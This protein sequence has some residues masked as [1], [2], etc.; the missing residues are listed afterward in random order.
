MKKIFTIIMLVMGISF[1][2]VAQNSLNTTLIG[3]WGYG[4]CYTVAES[5]N[6]A[7][8]GSG[9]MLLA[10]D[11]TIPS[12]PQKIG[13]LSLPDVIND[14]KIS[15]N[16]AYIADN[17]T[18]LRIINISNPT[19]LQ[20]TG[21]YDTPGD[22]LG[23]TVSGN[24]A[25]VADKYAGLRIID[26]SNPAS[27]QEVGFYNTPGIASSVSISGNYAYIADGNFYG[28]R[29]VDISNP[30]CPQEIGAYGMSSWAQGVSVSRNYV[31]VADDD[32]G[33]RIIDVS[34]PASPQE[35]GFYATPERALCV[36]VSGNYAYVAD[37]NAGML[38]IQND[39]LVGIDNPVSNQGNGYVQNYPNPFTSNTTLTFNMENKAQVNLSFYD[40]LGNK[41]T[42]LLNKELPAGEY[43]IP[44]D[45]SGLKNG[46]YYYTLTYGNITKTGKMVKAE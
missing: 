39:L 31:Y 19:N 8:M 41:V 17:E 28:L 45:G 44:F 21:F 32:A 43:Q 11:K 42:E 27:P 6:Y 4:P 35:V 5:G 29:I 2:L 40:C 18:G 1:S 13:E 24:Y 12:T 22:A 16:Y 3:H 46:M 38:I 25:Y 9:C 15:G 33:L 36:T 34:N 7:Y 37:E 14:I 20:E 23:V 26:I 30:S 10:L